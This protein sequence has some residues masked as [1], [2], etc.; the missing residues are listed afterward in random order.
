MKS[1][2][3]S[4]ARTHISEVFS[5]ALVAGPQKIE[6]RDSEPVVMVAESAWKRLAGAYATFADM[7]LNA[8]IDPDDLPARRPARV[9][10]D[11]KEF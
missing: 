9:L 1:W 4:E 2:T 11:D 3:I 6:R 10:A 8:P 5:A 7:V